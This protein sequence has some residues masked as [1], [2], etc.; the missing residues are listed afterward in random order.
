MT[1]DLKSSN[2]GQRETSARSYSLIAS[3]Y[4]SMNSLLTGGQNTAAR[5]SQ[6]EEIEPGDRVLYAGAGTCD[7]ALEAALKGAKVTCLD[8]S[9]GMLEKGRQRFEK[10]G[11]VGEFVCCNIMEYTPDEPF[12]IVTANFF[13]NVFSRPVMEKVLKKVVSFVR[14][15]G[16]L[17]IADF[18]RPYGNPL[19]MV[20]HS[21]MFHGTFIAHWALGLASLH[22][23]YDYTRY[24]Q[25]LGMKLTGRKRFRLY[26]K[27]PWLF[28][29]V[30]GIKVGDKEADAGVTA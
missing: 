1:A 13:L 16:K 2:D 26:W 15:D 20:I 30:S 21:M 19:L 22:L 11:L 25:K 3:I 17:L 18:A 29:M 8:L 9:P 28:E 6:L 12:D 27:G 5:L 10:A 24:Y 4:D 7:D 23:I 14:P